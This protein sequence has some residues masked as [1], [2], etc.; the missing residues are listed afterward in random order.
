MDGV[1]ASFK[2][3]LENKL[4]LGGRGLGENG[5]NLYASQIFLGLCI[6]Y[7]FVKNN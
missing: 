4:D 2:T 1:V 7:A 6:V 5:L 3:L